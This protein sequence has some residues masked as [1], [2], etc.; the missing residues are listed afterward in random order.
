MTDIDKIAKQLKAW[1][2]VAGTLF[3][4][5]VVA[6]VF[7]RTLVVDIDSTKENLA[8]T[9]HKLTAAEDRITEL[10]GS[11]IRWEI[12]IGTLENVVDLLKLKVGLVKGTYT[13]EAGLKGV[14]DSVYNEN[15]KP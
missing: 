3:G 7:I 14:P 10:E 15:N 9:K 4:L 13:L 12:S 8:D 2:Y 11:K 6:A 1:K 5:L